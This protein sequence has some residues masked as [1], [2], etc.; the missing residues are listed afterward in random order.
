MDE[1]TQEEADTRVVHVQHSLECGYR[2]IVFRTVDT[3]IVVIL[4]V[5]FFDLKSQYPQ[6]ELCVAFGT[7]KYFRYIHVNSICFSLGKRESEAM[8]AFHAYS[9]CDSTS[10]FRG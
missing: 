9:G 1:C 7:G 6:L 5:H 4:I 3:D 8:P 2:K 10:S